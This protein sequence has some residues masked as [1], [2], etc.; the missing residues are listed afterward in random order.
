MSI[1]LRC[2]V[3]QKEADK[4]AALLANVSD[5]LL[6]HIPLYEIGKTLEISR[7]DILNIFIQG[8][9]DGVFILDW[10]YHCPTCGHVAYEA[11]S[12][13]QA[14]SQNF[15]TVCN[16]AFDN[17]LDT[18]VEVCFSIHPRLKTIDPIYKMNYLAT[19]GK[20]IREGKYRTWDKPE[21]VRG[22]DIIQNNLYR[23][24]MRSEVLIGNQ[25]LR[26]ANATVL[27]TDIKNSTKLY[28]SLGDAK[29]FSLLKEYAKILFAVIKKCGGVPVKTI[30]DGVMGV[31]TDSGKAVSA[32]VKAQ[33]QLIKHAQNKPVT[34]RLEIKMGLHSGPVLVVNLNNR[35]DYFGLTVNT[36]AHIKDTALPNEVVI[37]QDL[38]NI[39]AV[40]RSILSV[41]DTVQRQQIQFNGNPDNHTLYHI[42]ISNPY[43]K[44]R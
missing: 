26:L 39:P 41:T 33:R 24:L 17:T 2:K 22:V 7:E 23:E 20:D 28:A 13:H 35:L 1:R 43:R 12:L 3:N 5:R 9:Y 10:I 6:F 42:K 14:S 30:G 8:V 36:A 4:I 38:F 44:N 15:C 16:E 19:I 34:D 18:N 25:S 29:A 27:F 40:K 21:S 37:S 31:F 11:P 32:A